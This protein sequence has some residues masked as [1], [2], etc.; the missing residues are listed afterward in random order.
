MDIEFHRKGRE[1]RKGL[2]SSEIPNPELAEG[3]GTYNLKD[4]GRLG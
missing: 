1:G 3:D 4:G 2:Y